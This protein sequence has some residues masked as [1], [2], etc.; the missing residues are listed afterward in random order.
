MFCLLKCLCCFLCFMLFP[1]AHSVKYIHVFLCVWFHKFTFLPLH[2]CI[3]FCLSFYCPEKNIIVTAGLLKLASLKINSKRVCVRSWGLVLFLWLWHLYIELQLEVLCDLNSDRTKHVS[4]VDTV[5]WR[6]C[7]LICRECV[8]SVRWSLMS[9]SCSGVLNTLYLRKTSKCR[10]HFMFKC[11]WGL[12]SQA[13]L[14]IC[15]CSL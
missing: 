6:L 1:A 14:W 9:S 7:C 11:K 12:R 5:K 10:S 3:L 8:A 15:L 13:F 4:G 2:T